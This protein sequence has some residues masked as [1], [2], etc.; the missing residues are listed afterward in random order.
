MASHFGVQDDA[1]HVRPGPHALPQ[2]LQFS[3][4]E[5]RST[6]LDPHG[7][8]GAAHVSVAHA[9]PLQTLPDGQ[10]PFPQHSKQPLPAQHR[11]PLA[12]EALNWH[13]PLLHVSAVHESPSLQSVLLQHSR[14]ATPQS[15][16][17]SAAQPHTPPPQTAP[18]LHATPQPPQWFPSVRV[19]TSQSEE[20]ESQSANPASHWGRP[21]THT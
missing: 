20:A 8:S 5:A 9:L 12:Q 10:S 17:V 4:S 2:P 14:Q 1:A 19:S 13:V 11:P 6:Q 3:G 15:R 21:S 18:G 7:I 16:G